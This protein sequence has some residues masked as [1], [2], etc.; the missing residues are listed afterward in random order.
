MRLD[1]WLGLFEHP[2]DVAALALFVVLFPVYHALYPLIIRRMPQRTAKGRLDRLRRSWIEGILERR[3]IITAAQQTRNLTMVNS[4]LAS[5]SLILM[6]VTANILVRLA[7]VSEDLPYPQGWEGKTDVM[8]GKLLLLIVVFAVAFAYSMT[9]LRHLGHFNL[10]IG[11]D[12]KVIDEQEG[13]AVDYLTS[14]INRGSN[15]YTLAVR[16]LYSA[17]CLFLWLF[18][19]WLFIACTL[20]W[21]IKFIFFQDFVAYRRR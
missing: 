7:E 14:L 10:V 2:L 4:L 5:S 21:G 8:A 15:R 12:P 3:D 1:Q 19:P 17:S 13:N 20:F 9:C 6:G 16:T 18:D 11:A